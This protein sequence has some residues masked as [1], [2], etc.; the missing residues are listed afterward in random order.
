M[1][2]S[3]V[4]FAALLVLAPFLARAEEPRREPE[5]A[6]P[7]AKANVAVKA[8]VARSINQRVRSGPLWPA[9]RP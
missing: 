2:R 3:V 7:A 6:P 5:P 9:A 1:N 8:E 4:L